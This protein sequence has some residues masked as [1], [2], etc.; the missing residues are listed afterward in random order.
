MAACTTSVVQYAPSVG[1]FLGSCQADHSG[2][3][4]GSW[5]SSTN[6]VINDRDNTATMDTLHLHIEVL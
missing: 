1:M 6:R 5:R 3:L 4:F 2:Y